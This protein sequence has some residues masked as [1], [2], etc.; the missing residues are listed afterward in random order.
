MSTPVKEIINSTYIHRTS[1]DSDIPY[2][3]STWTQSFLQD[4]ETGQSHRSSIFLNNYR[5]V[6]D[7]I[8][9]K[10]DTTVLVAC[11]PEDE[12]F[13]AGYIVFEPT[14][15]HYVYTRGPL[16][17]FGIAR[18]LYRAAFPA[19]E[20]IYYTHKTVDSKPIL[21]RLAIAPQYN[22]FLLFKQGD[23]YNA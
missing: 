14:I 8:L 22:Q 11:L 5:Y 15:L 6:I 16:K 7:N 12:R 19:R 10:P 1:K 21:K 13:I 3:Y 20:P 2:L 17:L 18:C 4:S 9:T 23:H